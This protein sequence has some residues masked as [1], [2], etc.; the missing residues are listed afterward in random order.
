MFI[1]DIEI[2]RKYHI[3]M[4]NINFYLFYMLKKYDMTYEIDLL[5]SRT[6]WLHLCGQIYY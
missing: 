6:L 1:C 4:K 2:S 3:S 5:V